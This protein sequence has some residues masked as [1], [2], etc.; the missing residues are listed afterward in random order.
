M[1]MVVIMRVTGMIL[2]GAILRVI[3]LSMP[4]RRLMGA[5]IPLLGQQ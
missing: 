4:F 2:E 5:G 3:V 1:L